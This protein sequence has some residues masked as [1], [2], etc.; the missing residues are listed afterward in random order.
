VIFKVKTVYIVYKSHGPWEGSS[1]Y[2]VC[3]N[4]KKAEWARDQL[5]K[6][7]GPGYEIEQIAVNMIYPFSLLQTTDKEKIP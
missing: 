6:R 4:K 7:D 5:R 1:I 3:T 2:A